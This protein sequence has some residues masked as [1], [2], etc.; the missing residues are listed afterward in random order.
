MNTRLFLTLLVSAL[1]AMISFHLGT[2]SQKEE[3]EE[4][5]RICAEELLGP[6]KCG[7]I[8]EYA[9]SLEAENS[10]LNAR[11][12]ACTETNSGVSGEL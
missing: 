6:D 10:R 9:V 2:Y 3:H 12:R 8:W 4:E 7:K 5:M 11:L 1:C